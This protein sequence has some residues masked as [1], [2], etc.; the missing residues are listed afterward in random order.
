[1]S[2]HDRKL[3]KTAWKPEMDEKSYILCGIC[4][5]GTECVVVTDCE[6]CERFK[7]NPC[8]H[9]CPKCKKHPRISLHAR[10]KLSRLDNVKDVKDKSKPQKEPVIKIDPEYFRS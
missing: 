6:E 1:M 7:L 5:D 2:K 9:W 8:K 10:N 3:W 4:N